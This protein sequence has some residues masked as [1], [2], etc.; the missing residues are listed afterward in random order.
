[1]QF[2]EVSPIECQH[3][4]LLR[5][6]VDED[7]IISDSLVRPACILTGQ[8]VVSKLA[9][10]YDDRE[11]E[12]L[13]GVECGHGSGFLVRL[14]RQ[15]D[16]LPMYS[17]VLQRRVQVF[18]RQIRMVAKDL[19]VA[20][21]QVS[22]LDDPRNRVTRIS[23]ARIAAAH[24]G[25]LLNPALRLYIP[26]GHAGSL[27]AHQPYSHSTA[28]LTSGPT[29]NSVPWVKAGFALAILTVDER[30]HEHPLPDRAR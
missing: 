7:L 27:S 2:C 24:S 23:N 6:R 11:A 10:L 4:P 9:K 17:V 12:I 21:T 20:Q 22:P 28:A 5:R 18:L 14:N 1:M 29:T 30:R 19:I 3:R 8:H 26:G 13:I 25:R 15:I 16:F